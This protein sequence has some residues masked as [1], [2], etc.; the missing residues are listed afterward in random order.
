MLAPQ[1]CPSALAAR[2]P[3]ATTHFP[4]QLEESGSGTDDF[5]ESRPLRFVIT[6]AQNCRGPLLSILPDVHKAEDKSGLLYKL[7]PCRCQLCYISFESSLPHSC[8]ASRA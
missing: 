4:V 5:S 7:L 3:K 8:K 1:A 6:P 2:V